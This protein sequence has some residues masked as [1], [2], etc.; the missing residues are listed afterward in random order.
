[1]TKPASKWWAQESAPTAKSQLQELTRRYWRMEGSLPERL[2]WYVDNLLPGELACADEEGSLTFQPCD[3][4]VFLVGHSIEPLLQTASVFQPAR[5]ILLL[6]RWYD[7]RGM[8]EPQTGI[9]WGEEINRFIGDRLASR[10]AYAPQVELQEV[11]DR[12]DA[13]FQVLCD[14]VLADRQEGR[15]IIVDITGAKKSIVAG[16]FLFAAYADIPISYVD[17]DEYDDLMRRP[18]GYTCRIGTLANPYDAFRLREWERVRR[19]YQGYHFHAAA[20]TLAGIM[21]RGEAKSSS[22]RAEDVAA[23]EALLALLRV[24]EAW[25]DGD[26]RR[27]SRALPGLQERVPGFVP[28][29]AVSLL[30]SVWPRSEDGAG[31]Q[32]AALQLLRLHDALR[33]GPRS[34]FRSNELLLAYARDELAKIERLVEGNEDNRSALLRAAGLDELLL[35]ARLIRLWHTG[36]IGL[37]DQDENYQGSCHDLGNASLRDKLYE[38]MINHHG[39]DHMRNALRRADVLDRRLGREVPA[40]VRIDVWRSSYRAR[41]LGRTLCL[42]EY[43]R[44]AALRGETLTD[45]R[46]QAIHMYLYVT[47]AIA[48]EA[49]AVARANLAEF[50]KRWAPLAGPLPPM[51]RTDVE[52]LPWDE[53]CGMC[54]VG[55]LPVALRPPHDRN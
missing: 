7:L 23:A 36:E 17:F 35:K 8:S 14:Q 47:D 4:L 19:L 54:G 6:N 53:V 41:P 31:A 11:S 18:L 32:E 10:L 30:G 24:Y 1:M 43:T 34:M 55:F 21:E 26:Y 42:V 27:A 2:G 39:T 49:V 50:E 22:L 46:N 33:Q 48:R 5:L 28:P 15:D 20:E 13:V 52:R 25:D 3:V 38:A 40:F 37:W 45:L 16:A 51:S 29:M 44:H 9:Q 12:P